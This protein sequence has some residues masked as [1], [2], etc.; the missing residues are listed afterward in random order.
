MYY[1][2]NVYKDRNACLGKVVNY[3]RRYVDDY[4]DR[5]DK[6]VKIRSLVDGK[7]AVRVAKELLDTY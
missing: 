3:L 7:G 2:G 1:A 4:Q 6:S 5:S